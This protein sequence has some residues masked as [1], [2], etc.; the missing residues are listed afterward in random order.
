MGASSPTRV[1]L[2]V[3]I[4]EPATTATREVTWLRTVLGTEIKGH[5]DKLHLV[6]QPQGSSNHQD[7]P[8]NLDTVLLPCHQHRDILLL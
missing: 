6:T 1:L 8:D 7:L 5:P 4:P 3:K 2:L